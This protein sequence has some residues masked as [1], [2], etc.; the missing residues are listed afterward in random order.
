[1]ILRVLI[2]DDES[3]ARDRLRQALADEKDVQIVGECGDGQ[4]ARAA[5]ERERPDILFLDVRMP[6]MDGFEV[7]ESLEPALVPW[8]I[9]VTA[10]AEH[11]IRAFETGALDYLLKPIIKDRVKAAVA[12]V[13]ERLRAGDPV[14]ALQE[15]L[16][17]RESSR[18]LAIRDGDRIVFVPVAAVDWVESAGNYVLVH[19]GGE[20]HVLRETLNRLEQRLPSEYFLRVSRSA[21]VN[22]HH[23]RQVR[24]LSLGRWSLRLANDQSLPVTR[25]LREL[26]QRL[27]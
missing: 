8:T 6:G 13:R 14:P 21:I 23:V 17:A 20:T 5:I 12:R 1:M 9:F 16:A 22:L 10:Y 18:R 19:T 15:W 11:A 25:N 4:S 7:L 2:V 26:E 27:S 24:H 3:L